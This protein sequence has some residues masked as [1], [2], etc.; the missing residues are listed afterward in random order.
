MLVNR[1]EFNVADAGAM[2]LG[3]TRVLRL[4]HV[5]RPSRS[6]SCSATPAIAWSIT[7]RKFL[8]VVRAAQQSS[9]ALEHIVL[10]D[11]DDEGT[12]SLAQLEQMGDADFDFDASW[13]AV[14][15]DDVAHADLHVRHDR[16]AE[17]RR[18]SRTAT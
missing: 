11:G 6:R 17:G 5:A 14:E 8:P 10:I 13:R 18:S 3:A 16:P 12:I 1:P 4:Q 9:P 15:P 2:H 7:E